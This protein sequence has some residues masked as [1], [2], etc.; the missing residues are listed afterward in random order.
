M[1]GT[2]VVVVVGAVVV[3]SFVDVN[4]EVTVV[5]EAV[6]MHEHAVLTILCSSLRSDDHKEA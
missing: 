5:V 6:S 3:V 2:T 1:I 4:V